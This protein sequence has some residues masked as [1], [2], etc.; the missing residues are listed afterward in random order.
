MSNAAQWDEG[1]G[2]DLDLRSILFKFLR[3]WYWFV[4]AA[5]IGLFVAHRYLSQYTPIYQVKDHGADRG[6]VVPAQGRR[7]TS[8]NS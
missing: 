5:G 8:C 4:I 3:Y 1:Q 6:R 7:T 2:D